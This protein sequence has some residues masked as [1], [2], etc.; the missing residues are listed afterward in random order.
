MN[1]KRIRFPLFLTIGILWGILLI[2]SW[3]QPAEAGLQAQLD[4][5]VDSLGVMS[6]T[7]APGVYEG[8]TRGYL[9]G[10]GL[11]MR[12][13]QTN[14]NLGSVGLPKVRAGCEGIDIY[15]G[16]FSYINADQLIAKLKAI[17]SASLGYAFMIALEAI[18]P[19]IAGSIKHWENVTNR[20]LNSNLS[21]CQAARALVDATGLPEKIRSSQISRCT[22]ARTSAGASTDFNAARQECAA[23]PG[24]GAVGD[25]EDQAQGRRDRNYLW[26]A[27]EGLSLD[28]VSRELILSAVGTIVAADDQ[29][30]LWPPQI[31]IDALLYGGE[32][33]RYDCTFDCLFQ[34]VVPEAATPGLTELVRQRLSAILAN[35][36]ARN[37][38]APADVD[39][40]STA[41]FPLYRMVN[42]LSTLTPAVAESY[43]ARW[44]E[45]LALLMVQHW[46]DTAARQARQALSVARVE[47]DVQ[48]ALQRLIKEA[49]GAV[50]ERIQRIRFVMD[51]LLDEVEMLERLERAITGSLSR[52][53][54]A[55]AYGFG[56]KQ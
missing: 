43:L 7:S 56:R 8:Q 35:I 5:M 33:N 55:K 27:L 16:A 24:S 14:L 40:V 2:L 23:D 26:E 41:P 6:T 48:E 45:P 1:R 53:D 13:P 20:I 49:K 42:A 9:T 17:G 38:L 44:A 54:L 10:G 19:Q 21:A 29:L 12:L 46:I 47:S 30:Y 39:F 37:D 22:G 31:G 36:Q 11:S 34:V 25:P 4:E 52:H 51:S 18:S 3:S 50:R 32:I 28:E 15:L